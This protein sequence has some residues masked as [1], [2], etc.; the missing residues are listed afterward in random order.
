MDGIIRALRAPLSS[1][2]AIEDSPPPVNLGNFTDF[3]S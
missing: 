3:K 1:A 2:A